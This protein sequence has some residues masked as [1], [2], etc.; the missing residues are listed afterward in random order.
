MKKLSL[1]LC[2]RNDNF[3]GNSLWRLETSVN[4]NAKRLKN[5]IK[6]SEIII[7]D[8]GSE[9]PLENVLKLNY[10]AKKIVKFNY[11]PP[12]KTKKIP[13]SFSEVHALNSAARISSGRWIGR[14]DQDTIIGK[15]FVNW[16]FKEGYKDESKFFFSLRRDMRK[17]EKFSVR[18]I[19]R[20]KLPSKKERD[21]IY[22]WRGAVGILLIPRK[23]YFYVRGYDETNIF[24][25][26]M[27]HE[28]IC[29]LKKRIQ[30]VDLG[31]IL[32]YDFYHIYHNKSANKILPHNPLINP[33]KLERS[34]KIIVNN[35]NWGKNEL[36]F[37]QLLI[38]YT[39]K[40]FVKFYNFIKK[41][42]PKKIKDFYKK[43]YLKNEK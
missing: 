19:E 31:K 12:E 35:L 23:E 33:K 7:S 21:S 20:W 13:S 17:N 26:H 40:N 38:V 10:F 32:N 8:W 9:V 3:C 24:R 36:S 22:F 29:R 28:L 14:I 34:K 18:S 39:K 41:I 6:E 37:K 15:R 30:L 16:F 5:Y 2:S 27:E 11:I 25:N 43:N 42:T 1:I 4:L